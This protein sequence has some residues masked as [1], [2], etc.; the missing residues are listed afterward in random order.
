MKFNG[1]IFTVKIYEGSKLI[2]RQITRDEMGA[3]L[4]IASN[5]VPPAVSK[6]FTI[7]VKCLY[8]LFTTFLMVPFSQIN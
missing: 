6:R 8:T 2:L 3:F 1:N 4:C 5:R 7:D